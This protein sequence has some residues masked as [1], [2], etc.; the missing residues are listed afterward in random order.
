MHTYQMEVLGDFAC[1]IDLKATHCGPPPSPVR[2]F[3]YEVHIKADRLDSLGFVVDNAQVKRYF[4]NLTW[5]ILQVSCEQLAEKACTD[6]WQE[7]FRSISVRLW[8]ANWANVEC[9]RKVKN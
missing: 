5:E 6:L 4:D 3:K 2:S 1:R 9:T 8:G 7:N